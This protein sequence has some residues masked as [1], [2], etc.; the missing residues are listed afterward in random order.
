MSTDITRGPKRCPSCG[1]ENPPTA[2]RCSLCATRLDAAIQAT[3]G[4]AW[5]EAYSPSLSDEE[6]P[7]RPPLTGCA[8]FAAAAGFAVLVVGSGLV[9]F[10]TVCAAA[11]AVHPLTSPQDPVSGGCVGVVLG[12]LAATVVVTIILIVLHFPHKGR[13]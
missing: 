1:R 6:P 7:P 4:P 12:G 2:V 10:F 5:S 3:P 9:T 13:R 11:V 8:A